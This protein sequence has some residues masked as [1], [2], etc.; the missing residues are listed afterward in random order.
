[1]GRQDLRKA[2]ESC[3]IQNFAP[4]GV[5]VIV[6]KDLFTLILIN[7]M[8]QISTVASWLLFTC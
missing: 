1:M 7:K 5:G 4:S 6:C 8:D 3:Q 2:W